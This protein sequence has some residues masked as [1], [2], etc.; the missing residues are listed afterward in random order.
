MDSSLTPDLPEDVS[1]DTR[2][3]QAGSRWD[4]R[5]GGISMPIHLAATFRHPGLGRS[6]GWDY[7][8]SGNP[9]G[10]VLEN[11]LA[12]IEGATHAF[13]F[14]SGMAAVD[15][16]LRLLAPGS[17]M[18]VPEEIYGGTWRILERIGEPWGL[19]VRWVSFRDL[20]ERPGDILGGAK[21]VLLETPTNPTLL[22]ADPA[23][24]LQAARQVGCLSVV[25][26]T[27]LTPVLVR[28]LELGADL[29]VHSATKYLSG[30]SDLTAGVVATRDQGLAERIA[31]LRNTTG[32]V[33]S[34]FDS[35][36]L[37]RG[38]KTLSLRVRRQQESAREL[39][40]LLPGLPGVV[41][42]LYPGRGGMVSFEVDSADRVRSLL[43]RVR[44]WI[45]AESLGGTES[46]VTVPASQTHSDVDAGVRER[47]GITDRLVRLSVG[48]EDPADLV[49]DLRSALEGEP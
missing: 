9:T 39:A 45:F 38:L 17:P 23:D 27:F 35:W 47:L 43:E 34:P 22:D 33:L 31:Y 21:M 14:A 12:T 20:V 36:L 25:D 19:K 3:A 18:V 44:V 1:Q 46:L 26:S 28:P 13:A 16:V 4:I 32:A 30:H 49:Q 48:L 2:L 24:V 8:R 5:T 42:V 29:V 6:T 40:S 15:T 10:Q 11:L 41:R 7:S 37:L